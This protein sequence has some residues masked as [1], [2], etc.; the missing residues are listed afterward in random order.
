M[1]WFAIAI[2]VV[3]VVALL[4]KKLYNGRGEDPFFYAS[5]A[6]LAIIAGVIFTFTGP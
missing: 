5:M 4:G 6:T 1:H 2:M 3:W